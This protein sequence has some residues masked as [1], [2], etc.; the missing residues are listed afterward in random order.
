VDL[1]SHEF[2]DEEE[3]PLDTPELSTSFTTHSV[4][5]SPS[6]NHRANSPPL[7]K[8]EKEF[9]QTARGM[10]K[11]KLS[12]DITMGTLPV[13]LPSIVLPGREYA[14]PRQMDVDSDLFGLSSRLGVVTG[15][16]VLPSSPAVKPLLP[17]VTISKKPMD[18]LTSLWSKV[19]EQMEWDMRSPEHI[20]LDELDNLMDDF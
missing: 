3:E 1:S 17:S 9:T 8:D 16:S 12:Q 4:H 13:Q 6:R 7:E 19:D 20:E 10:Q 11:R 18:D 15:H 2:D 14:L 5:Q